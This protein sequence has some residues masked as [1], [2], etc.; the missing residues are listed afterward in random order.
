MLV[1]SV[2]VVLLSVFIHYMHCGIGWLDMYLLLS[3][4]AASQPASLT[5][6]LNL[7]LIIPILLLAAASFLYWKNKAHQFIPV[8]IMLALTFGSISIIAGGDGMVEYH[9][10]IFMVLASLAYFESVRLVVISTIHFYFST[11][12]RLL[13]D[14]GTFMWN[15][16]LSFHIIDDSCRIFT[17][18]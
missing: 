13:Y 18:Y 7:I 11:S 16:G 8:L 6:L 15:R 4:T 3:Q 12:R 14:S 17:F 9:F 5:P 2:V 1:F 10:S